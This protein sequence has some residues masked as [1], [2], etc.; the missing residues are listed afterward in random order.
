M[1][2]DKYC[3]ECDCS[4]TFNI[5]LPQLEAEKLVCP[6]CGMSV[7]WLGKIKNR[8]NHEEKA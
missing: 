6:T 5:E 7:G 1:K 3:H 8:E 2:I 4:K